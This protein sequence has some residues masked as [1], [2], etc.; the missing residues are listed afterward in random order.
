MRGAKG[1]VN[2]NVAE[3]GQ[4]HR[5]LL[6]ILLLFRMEPEVLEQ[7]HVAIL[8]LRD[9]T[10]DLLANAIFNKVNCQRRMNAYRAVDYDV[11]CRRAQQL[12]KP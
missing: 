9:R 8:H 12:L 4:L 1:I 3:R 11:S 2:I 7:Q 5:K 10:S 6:I